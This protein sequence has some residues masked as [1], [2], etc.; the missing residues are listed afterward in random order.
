[1]GGFL[2]SVGSPSATT[3][4]FVD[5]ITLLSRG[6]VGVVLWCWFL[7]SICSEALAAGV[8]DPKLLEE[9]NQTL[10]EEIKLASRPQVYLML[11][12]SRRTI[13]LKS[14][15]IDLHRYSVLDWHASGE[16]PRVG[17]Y[18]LKA[19]PPVTRPKAVP[20]QD[21]SEHPV[22]L[23]DMPNDYV[24]PFDNGLIIAVVPSAFDHPWSWLKR[25]LWIGWG[26]LAAWFLAVTTEAGTS[27]TPDLVLT[28]SLEDA[29]GLAWTV[30]EGMMLLV[31]RTESP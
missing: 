5:G 3:S 6:I 25:M 7:G 2:A 24:L 1:M 21:S 23:D 4:R 26:R 15:G 11:D 18:R 14:H 31:G 8:L 13:F 16:P 19:R 10:E 29:Q 28:L 20:G 17:A 22:S 12:L 27:P 9:L 30:T